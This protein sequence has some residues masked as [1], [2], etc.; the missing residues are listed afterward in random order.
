MTTG[1][2]L[3]RP[4]G[5]GA[6]AGEGIRRLWGVRGV[7]LRLPTAA[8]VCLPCRRVPRPTNGR[9]RTIVRT[10]SRRRSTGI[11]L[12]ITGSPIPGSL[13]PIPTTGSRTCTRLPISIQGGE[14]LEFGVPAAG[15]VPGGGLAEEAGLGQGLI[16]RATAEGGEGAAG[17]EEVADLRCRITTT[18]GRAPA[19]PVAAAVLVGLGLV[20]ARVLDAVDAAG[21]GRRERHRCCRTECARNVQNDGSSLSLSLAFPLC[22]PV[23]SV[24]ILVVNSFCSL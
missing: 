10:E 18:G 11:R 9:T 13:I 23:V 15:G 17:G 7:A 12:R 19:A 8:A 4:R 2:D 24:H 14:V 3:L 6:G 16:P 5:R 22:P 1:A 20:P 21:E